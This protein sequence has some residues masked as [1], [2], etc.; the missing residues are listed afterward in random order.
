MIQMWWALLRFLKAV[1][2]PP[3]FTELEEY[4]TQQVSYLESQLNIERERYLE[5]SNKVMFPDTPPVE[6]M[7]GPLSTEP[8]INKE[9]AERKRLSDLSKIRW[10]E[11]IARQE[12]RATELMQL[13]EARAKDAR[14]ETA[15]GQSS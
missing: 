11:H 12:L 1:F 13:D 14:N 2:V 10:Q 9:A 15:S 5:L 7:R 3:K 4:L 6:M 8:P